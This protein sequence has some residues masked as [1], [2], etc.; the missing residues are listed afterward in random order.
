MLRVE[1]NRPDPRFAPPASPPLFL[2]HIMPSTYD[3]PLI[4]ASFPSDGV[5]VLAL[6]RP[7][8]NAFSTSLFHQLEDSFRTA[9]SDSDVRCIVLT[10]EVDKGFTAGL[11]L[12]CVAFAPLPLPP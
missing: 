7:P 2:N 8:V 3:A 12:Q 9:S 1:A 5:L 4:K 11:D 6:A 10:S